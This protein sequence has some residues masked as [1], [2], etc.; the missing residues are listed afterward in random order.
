MYYLFEETIAGLQRQYDEDVMAN[1]IYNIFVW[2]IGFFVVLLIG[3]LI[4]QYMTQTYAVK[5]DETEKSLIQAQQR[6]AF[7]EGAEGE[8]SEEI[9]SLRKRMVIL[10]QQ[11]N[12][13]LGL[14]KKMYDVVRNGEK[15]SVTD[16]ERWLIK[17][18]S[19]LHYEK[20]NQWQQEYKHLSDRLLTF[21]ILK[22]MGKTDSDIKRILSISDVA[23]RATKSRLNRNKR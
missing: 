13:Q 22:E 21:L 20:Y 18:F 17:Y 16:N 2:I 1:S 10:Q 8:H 7:L 12:E 15:L 14:G 3:A 9:N 5:I 6:I 19:V 4:Y 23:F 11:S